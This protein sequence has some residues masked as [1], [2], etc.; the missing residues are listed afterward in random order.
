M[1]EQI[2][3]SAGIGGSLSLEFANT[4]GWHLSPEPAE[5][6]Q[7]WQDVVAWAVEQGLIESDQAAAFSHMEIELERVHALREAIFR[8]GLAVARSE[9]PDEADLNAVVQRA[10][11]SLP[12]PIWSGKSLRWHFDQA[13][14]PLSLLGLV[15]RDFVALLA[16]ERAAKLRLCAGPDCGWLFIDE[17]RSKPRRWCSMSDCGNRSKARRA[18]ARRKG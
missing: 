12:T 16:S 4:A 15:A 6:L 7:T 3:I 5:R 9:D 8:I 14:V 10:S 11:G 18:Y 2:R 13:I 17:S 1:T